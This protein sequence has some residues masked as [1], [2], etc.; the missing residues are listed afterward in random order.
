VL[1]L[2]TLLAFWPNTEFG[3]NYASDLRSRL[4]SL[5]RDL[6]GGV[7]SP[8]LIRLYH[9]HLNPHPN[10]LADYFPM[11][12]QAGVGQ[13]RLLRETPPLHRIPVPL[14]PAALG[15]VMWLDATASAAGP[16]PYLEFELP[17]DTYVY[18]V[19][20][21]YRTSGARVSFP[22]VTISW[23]RNG[24]EPFDR[25]RCY[26]YYPTGDRANWKNGAWTR[27]DDPDT[28]ATAWVCDRVR[29][30]RIEP[31][32]KPGALRMLELALLVPAED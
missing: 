4:G 30:L 1:L 8:L 31:D 18:G 21:R 20:L 13:F 19:S 22:F 2:A 7:P 12:R 5:E 27:R 17:A 25:S 24:R 32:L 14:V 3:L 6:A 11:L 23:I 29:R 28:T 16:R 26:K 15:D 10:L 9:A